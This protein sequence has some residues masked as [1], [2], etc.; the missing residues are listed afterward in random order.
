MNDVCV[1]GE[2]D[3]ALDSAERIQKAYEEFQLH[4]H[5]RMQLA[6]QQIDS[7]TND[8]DTLRSELTSSK[9]ELKDLQKKVHQLTKDC[10]TERDAREQLEQLNADI[11]AEL[12]RAG[13]RVAD[14][15]TKLS[16]CESLQRENNNLKLTVEQQRI[17]LERCQ[18]EIGESRAQLG[19]LED[20]AQRLQ[21]SMT[22]V[23][24]SQKTSQTNNSSLHLSLLSV[25]ADASSISSIS[26][27]AGPNVK[28]NDMKT[29]VAVLESEFQQARQEAEMMKSDL[30][31]E[32]MEVQRLK[33]ALDSETEQATGAVAEMA[34]IGARTVRELELSLARLEDEREKHLS[35]ISTLESRIAD[36][37]ARKAAA[38]A[39]L[40][41]RGQQLETTRRELTD[42]GAKEAA[43]SREVRKQTLQIAS[44]ERQLDEKVSEIATQVKRSAALSDK[45]Q[46]LLSELRRAREERDEQ[47][48]IAVE[49]ASACAQ[50]RQLHDAQ[51]HQMEAS[52]ASL[53]EQRHVMDEALSE[54]DARTAE[55]QQD[56]TKMT[57]QTNALRQELSRREQNEREIS[58]VLEHRAVQA[59]EL[60]SH[61][62][63]ELQCYQTECEQLRAQCSEANN[64]IHS[65]QEHISKLNEMLKDTS[66]IETQLKKAVQEQKNR[67]AEHEESSE[68]DR[69]R[70][71]EAE[72]KLTELECEQVRLLSQ[73]AQSEHALQ[74]R[75]TEYK[76]EIEALQK[77]LDSACSELEQRND[78]VQE[79]RSAV[80]NAQLERSR[81]MEDVGGQLKTC[82]K[83]LKQQSKIC[84]DLQAEIS[85]LKAELDLSA[86]TCEEKD[87]KVKNLSEQLEK[88]ESS[89]Q[90][91]SL[92]R[93]QLFSEL[94]QLKRTSR[95]ELAQKLEE[96]NQE[97]S[98]LKAEIET[99]RANLRRCEDALR[100]KEKEAE[101][102]TSSLQV[103]T[104]GV[105]LD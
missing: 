95:T 13:V 35:T 38:D 99:V 46:S 94:E 62:E 82:R 36:L 37:E 70:L 91:V 19:Q 25:K 71:Q 93:Q 16:S 61:L 42:H 15:E 7:T 103:Q 10:S 51:C 12:T 8:R 90:L 18:A 43:F 78:E 34:E 60:V 29:K 76:S 83:Q 11:H 33:V 69:Q 49:N 26:A 44:L 9:A 52:I 63:T 73:I 40:A 21:Q 96:H 20:L 14:L 45:E 105:V 87:G 24:G 79:L 17:S 50:M 92:E 31:S 97:V 75:T 47:S 72:T 30:E 100:S 74:C 68:R 77:K 22:A 101:S 56:L 27:S 80:R 5:D 4:V 66:G 102:L 32:R 85:Q 41:Q 88:V 3:L 55:L 39:E 53:N 86:A 2:R 48:R 6:Q 89:L 28:L 58:E 54:S 57:E 65:A 67:A 104:V 64:E 1:P 98:A 81:T 59:E 84:D 23:Q